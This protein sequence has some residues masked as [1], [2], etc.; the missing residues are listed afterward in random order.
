MHNVLDKTNTKISVRFN[1]SND[2]VFKMFDTLTY[3]KDEFKEHYGNKITFYVAPLFE[4]VQNEGTAIEGFWEEL[5]RISKSFNVSKLNKC[6]EMLKDGVFRRERL[7]RHCMAFNASGMAIMPN[8][9]F[10]PCEHIKDED[11]FGDVVNGVTNFEV[12]KRWQTFDGPE[13]QFCKD[14]KC[15]YHPMC[16]KFFRCDS[17]VVCQSENF[18]NMRINKAKEKLIRTR[19]YYNSQMYNN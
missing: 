19:S 15:P 5:D 10:T 18:K 1:A 11:I 3:L 16:P 8:G 12:I 7:D 9:K 6:D 4:Y 14:S 13:I 2:N 17:G